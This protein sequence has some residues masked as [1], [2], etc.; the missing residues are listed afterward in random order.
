VSSQFGIAGVDPATFLAEA[1]R[2][3]VGEARA[4][5]LSTDGLAA[6]LIAFLCEYRPE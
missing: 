6:Q 5:A 3:G 4:G 2:G 1:H